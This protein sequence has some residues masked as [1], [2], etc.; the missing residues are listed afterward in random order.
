MKTWEGK[1]FDNYF[2]GLGSGEKDIIINP[3]N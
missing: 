2:E 1:K 3:T